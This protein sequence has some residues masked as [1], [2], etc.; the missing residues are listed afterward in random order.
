MDC[1]SLAVQ[2]YDLILSPVEVLP[3]LYYSEWSDE[4]KLNLICLDP[5]YWAELFRVF[6]S[7]FLYFLF[8]SAAPAE[9]KKRFK[10]SKNE[11]LLISMVF[12]TAG[13][14]LMFM[15]LIYPLY[16]YLFWLPGQKKTHHGLV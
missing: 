16:N 6:Y 14:C 12:A 1:G 13:Q 4:Q 10:V 9:Q 2:T 15:Q 5:S 3:K 7:H 8:F 11:F